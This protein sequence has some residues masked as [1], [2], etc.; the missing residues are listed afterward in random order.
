MLERRV[1]K[2]R[3]ANEDSREK[4]VKEA[5]DSIKNAWTENVRFDRGAVERVCELSPKFTSSYSQKF[6]AYSPIPVLQTQTALDEICLRNKKM[7]VLGRLDHHAPKT[8]TQLS[9]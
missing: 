3:L 4:M 1:P 6:L 2:F 7:V 5:A 8:N 9:A